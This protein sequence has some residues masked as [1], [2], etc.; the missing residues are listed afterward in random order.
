M[1]ERIPM[2]SNVTVSTFLLYM[3]YIYVFVALFTSFYRC[4]FLDLLMSLL[5]FSSFQI[6]IPQYI[7]SFANKIIGGIILQT[8]FDIFWFIICFKPWWNTAMDDAFQ[9]LWLRRA[10]VVFS[11]ILLAVRT[12]VLVAI[13]ISYRNMDFGKDEFV[14]NNTIGQIAT[15]DPNSNKNMDYPGFN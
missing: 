11:F 3:V 13:L 5:L 7:R 1:F 2:A 10:T 9:L 15:F 12:L 4:V 14:Q 8:I 6:N